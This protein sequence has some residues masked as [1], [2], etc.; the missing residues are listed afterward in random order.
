MIPVWRI[1][2]IFNN[3]LPCSGAWQQNYA[4]LRPCPFLI[5][6]LRENT[7]TLVSVMG[8]IIPMTMVRGQLL[9]M[10]TVIGLHIRTGQIL[11]WWNWRCVRT[12]SRA[13]WNEILRYSDKHPVQWP[14]PDYLM[15]IKTKKMY[16]WESWLVHYAIPA[17]IILPG[18]FYQEFLETC[19]GRF[20]SD[21]DNSKTQIQ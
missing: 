10:T 18:I 17:G 14:N 11:M 2:L 16:I 6:A 5:D 8:I 20:H 3:R 19:T 9:V 4:I 7:V 1:V 12:N 15:N 13:F 21:V